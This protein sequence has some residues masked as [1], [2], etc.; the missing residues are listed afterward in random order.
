MF[1]LLL[2]YLTQFFTLDL[3]IKPKM[4][5]FKN[6]E[7]IFQKPVVTL[8]IVEKIMDRIKHKNFFFNNNNSQ[9]VLYTNY[10]NLKKYL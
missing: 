6:L 9:D 4:C 10:F 5:T 1:S 3:N 7:E 8:Y 2:Y